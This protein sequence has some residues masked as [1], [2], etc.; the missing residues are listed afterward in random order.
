MSA[1]LE[2][3]LCLL[4]WKKRTGVYAGLQAALTSGGKAWEERW[5]VVAGTRLLYYRLG[6]EDKEEP[7]GSIDLITEQA[8]IQVSSKTSPDAPSKHEINIIAGKISSAGEKN[9]NGKNNTKPSSS[10]AAKSATVKQ[11]KFCFHSQ[12]DLMQF[13]ETVHKVQDEAGHYQSKDT[14][15]FE[16]DFFAGDHLYRWEVRTVL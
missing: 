9:S 15:R 11:W 14:T 2:G 8:E 7:R 13:L 10:A 5:I 12:P 1:L 3:G 6:E 16:H 4:A